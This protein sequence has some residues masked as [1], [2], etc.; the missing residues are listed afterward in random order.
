MRH[1]SLF[2]ILSFCATTAVA[3]GDAVDTPTETTQTG[4]TEPNGPNLQRGT[5]PYNPTD[6]GPRTE[7]PR[8]E[9]PRTEDPRTEDPR[10]EDPRTEDPR[11]EDPPCVDPNAGGSDVNLCFNTADCCSGFCTYTGM[12]YV[13]GTCASQVSDGSDCETDAWCLSGYCTDGVCQETECEGVGSSCWSASDCCGSTFCAEGGGYAPGTCTKPQPDGAA[14]WWHDWCQ[15]G[16]CTDGICTSESC[17]DNGQNCY[18]GGECCTGL[19]TYDMNNPYIP[20]SCFSVQ[21]NG[22]HCLDDTWCASG[23]CVDGTC[24]A[25]GCQDG[26]QECWHDSACCD[27]FCTYN[28]ASGYTPGVCQKLLG[29]DAFCLSDT[30][31]ESGHCADGSCQNASCMDL[32]AECYSGADCCSGLCTY[33]GQSYIQGVCTTPQPAG[34]ACVADMWCES[35]SCVDGE[36]ADLSEVILTFSEI[37]ETV[38]ESNGCAGGYCHSDP[39]GAL[40]FLD[41]DEAYWSL[42]D[43]QV[44]QPMCGIDTYVVPGDPEASLLWHKVRPYVDDAPWCGDKMPLGTMGLPAADA[45]LVEAWIAQGA[46]P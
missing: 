8:T 25:K 36:C 33:D 16:V 46:H 39:F 35:T 41:E 44:Y 27:G 14:C 23:Q 34:A 19:C 28:G 17:G 11:I 21:D 31:C 43:M 12:D 9:D 18:D 38:F 5:E 10:T 1:L 3:C 15:S 2:L 40:N 7:D 45:A 4:V 29:L 30:W 32:D 6:S 20:G 22:M 13:P 42:V 37:Y 24:G 26:D